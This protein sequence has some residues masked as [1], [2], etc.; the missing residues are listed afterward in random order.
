[1]NHWYKPGPDHI[2]SLHVLRIHRSAKLPAVCVHTSREPPEANHRW[3]FTVSVFHC[4]SPCGTTMQEISEPRGED[5]SSYFMQRSIW[6]TLHPGNCWNEW[7]HAGNYSGG[8]LLC[9]ARPVESI[10][11]LPCPLHWGPGL[12]RVLVESHPDWVIPQFFFSPSWSTAWKKGKLFSQVTFTHF[13]THAVEGLSVREVG[14]Q[15]MLW[16]VFHLI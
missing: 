8:V 7:M 11:R 2:L 10:F 6:R 16:R 14:T 9:S 13:Q 12:P 4:L 3:Y 5:S 15:Y 1:M